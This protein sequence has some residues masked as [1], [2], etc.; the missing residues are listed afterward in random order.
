MSAQ[1]L[2]S[3]KN[4]S[5][6]CLLETLLTRTQVEHTLVSTPFTFWLIRKDPLHALARFESEIQRG[7]HC[8]TARSSPEGIVS[9]MLSDTSSYNL[10]V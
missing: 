2:I 4:C 9:V 1:C 10:C 8:L 6:P 5:D 3:P 7:L